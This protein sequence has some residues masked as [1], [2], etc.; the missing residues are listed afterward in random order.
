MTALNTIIGFKLFYLVVKDEDIST[1]LCKSGIL[2][3]DLNII[4]NNKIWVNVNNIEKVT[5]AK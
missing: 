4:P 2:R 1:K 5:K 3:G